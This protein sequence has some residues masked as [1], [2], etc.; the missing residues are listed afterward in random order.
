MATS[1]TTERNPAARAGVSMKSH[2]S[3]RV[4]R[5]S[6]LESDIAKYGRRDPSPRGFGE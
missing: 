6:E 2:D 4:N 3:R 1:K 5:P